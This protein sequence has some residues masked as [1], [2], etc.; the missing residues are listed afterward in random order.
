[1][2]VLDDCRS[3]LALLAVLGLGGCVYMPRT[4]TNYDRDCQVTTH[5][6]TLDVQQVAALGKCDNV[7]C[8]AELAFFGAA[9]VATA[10]VSGSIVLVGNVVYWLEKQ[11]QCIEGDAKRPSSS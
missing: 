11:G 7:T 4:T 10:I 1:M 6:M 9:S 8:P 3:W 2:D 5:H